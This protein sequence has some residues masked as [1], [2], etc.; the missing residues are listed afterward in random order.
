MR[1]PLSNCCCCPGEHASQGADAVRRDDL[2]RESVERFIAAELANRALSSNFITEA[3]DLSRST[4]YRLFERQGG[5]ARRPVDAVRRSPKA[6][7]MEPIVDLAARSG[8]VSEGHL[9]RVFAQAYGVPPGG[10]RASVRAIPEVDVH[11]GR[12]R[13]SGWL[14]EL[15]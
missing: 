11:T 7:S 15:I 12:R 1:A 9:S 13:W 6:G 2:R 5:I 8:F 4:L 3:T 14:S 10:Y